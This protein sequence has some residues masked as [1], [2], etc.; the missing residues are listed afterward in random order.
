MP[1]K[2]SVATL[3]F[4]FAFNYDGGV[5]KFWIFGPNFSQKDIIWTTS[6]RFSN[7]DYYNIVK[8]IALSKFETDDSIHAVKSGFGETY[9]NIPLQDFPKDYLTCYLTFYSNGK[10]ISI[11]TLNSMVK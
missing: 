2:N 5:S 9:Y 3:N 4:E 11:E 8:R 1:V 7:Q 10:E 6:G